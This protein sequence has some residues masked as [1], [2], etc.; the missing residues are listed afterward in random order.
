MNSNE[1]RS[2]FDE[3]YSAINETK[4]LRMITQQ[5][6]QTCDVTLILLKK[7]ESILVS[8]LDDTEARKLALTVLGRSSHV[9]TR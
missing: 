5:L 6:M 1:P 9:S 3:R 8:D 4:R 7:I 2:M